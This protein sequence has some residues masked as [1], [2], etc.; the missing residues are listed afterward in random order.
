PQQTAAPQETLPP[1]DATPQQPPSV[2]SP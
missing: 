1:C 2:L